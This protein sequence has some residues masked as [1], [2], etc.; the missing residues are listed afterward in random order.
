MAAF[1]VL[2]EE[3]LVLAFRLIGVQ[4][5]AVS[6][7]LGDNRELVEAF[8]AATKVGDAKVLILSEELGE[9]LGDELV[10]WQLAGSLPLVVEIPSTQGPRLDRRSLAELVREAVGVAI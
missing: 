9:R 3:E 10:E 4:G 8:R 6:P 5:R 1:F 7:R 2:A